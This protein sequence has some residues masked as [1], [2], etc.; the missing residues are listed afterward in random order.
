MPHVSSVLKRFEHNPYNYVVRLSNTSCQ[1]RIRVMM[2]MR[3]L[4]SL[5]LHSITNARADPETDKLFALV[6]RLLK[7]LYR[8]REY[9][10]TV[11]TKNPTLQHSYF[12]TRP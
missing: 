2:L 1:V 3:K 8:D 5:G 10:T 7:T 11:W 6:R 4:A 9:C 12:E